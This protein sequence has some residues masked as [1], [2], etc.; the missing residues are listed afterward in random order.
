MRETFSILF[1]LVIIALALCS[2]FAHKSKKS[3]GFATSV[4]CVSFIIPVVGNLILL[5]SKNELF[6]TIGCYTYFIGMNL[7]G[8]SLIDFSFAY[9]NIHWK[10]TKIS[11]VAYTLLTLDLI[12]YI[13]NPF[14]HHAFGVESIIVDGS[15]FYRSV[16]YIG[17]TYHRIAV[18]LACLLSIGMFIVKSFKVPKIYAER[19]YII[20]ITM[21]LGGAWASY[22]VS[23]RTPIDTSM[24]GIGAL[25]I[26]LYYFS[27]VYRPFKLLDRILANIAA[28]ITDFIYFFDAND[29]CVWAN[30]PGLK[31]LQIDEEKIERAPQLLAAQF[32]EINNEDPEWSAKEVIGSG[33]DAQYFTLKKHCVNDHKGHKIGSFIR[34]Q[35]ITEAE[36]RQRHK[37]YKATHDKL[38]DLYTKDYLF[39]TVKQVINEGDD[40]PFWIAYLD[41]KDF[42]MVNDIFGASV[43]DEL[44][45]RIA[46]WL[47]KNRT[48][49]QWVYG[50]ISG[51]AFGICFAADRP[52]EYL[53]ERR[54][55]KFSISNGSFEQHVLVHIGFYKVIDPT[56]DVSIMFDRAHL[57]QTTIKAEYN[58]HIAFYDDKMREQVLWDQKISSQLEQAIARREICPYLQPIVDSDGNIIGAEALVR[59]I[60]PEEGFLAPYKFIPVFEKN[61]M[62]A[63]VDKFIWRRACETLA[64]WRGDKSKMFI[65]INISPKD[66]FFMDVFTEIYSLV[67]EY[68]IRPSRLRIEITE[69]IMMTDAESRM[70]ILRRF[71]DAGFIV[72]MDDFG[73]GYSSLN[74]LKDMP[75]DV[76]KI[77]MKFLSK[78]ENSHKAEIILRN[79]LRLSSDLGLYSLT[80]GVETEEQY[81]MLREMGCNLFQGYYFA[82]PMAVDE[83]EKLCD[84]QSEEKLSGT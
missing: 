21:A 54:L 75:L 77:D 25:G 71:R 29:R 46:L 82:K 45:K 66:F 69:T 76:L 20:A 49:Q 38:T 1:V 32:K 16:P 23:S 62:I 63:E 10:D 40:K 39:E 30:E 51:D 64:S 7:L 59:W 33:E 42:K 13:F 24:V 17:Q 41:V 67:Q 26:C 56:I 60:H 6:S 48:S 15:V 14:F 57:A 70:D 34:I 47:K 27:I 28:R 9:C 55:S 74:Q 37:I 61:G 65:S 52:D 84:K 78:S 58:K 72:E 81:K 43:G 4:L 73:S 44:L 11:Y 8:F 3:I 83:F 22:Y 36:H 19:Y 53:I 68:G 35:D 18:Y 50:R 79:V 2:F 12:Q 5:V 80:E 31:Y